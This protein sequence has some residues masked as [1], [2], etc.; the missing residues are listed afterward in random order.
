[1]EFREAVLPLA[2]RHPVGLPAG[3]PLRGLL[4]QETGERRI[5]LY[6]RWYEH[7]GPDEL[8]RWVKRPLVDPGHRLAV[9]ALW[10]QLVADVQLGLP[11]PQHLPH[12]R[13]RLLLR[14]L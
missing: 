11:S 4:A 12:T 14:E 2:Q 1:M 3:E 7:V 6:S 10:S 8:P 13:R 9:L 5:P